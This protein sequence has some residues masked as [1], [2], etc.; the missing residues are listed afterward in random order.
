MKKII[1][2]FLLL[3]ITV[4]AY[5]QFTTT[6]IWEHPVMPTSSDTI[7][8]NPGSKLT[9]ADFRGQPNSNSVATAITASGFGYT[10]SMRSVNNRTSLVITVYCYF[11]KNNSWVKRGMKTDYAL[12]HE[13]HHFDITYIATAAFVNKLKDAVFTKSNYESL[14]EKL[15]SECYADL[16]KMQNAYDGDTKNGQ[17]KNVQAIWNDKLDLLLSQTVIH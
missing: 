9:W 5:P 1:F 12:T 7:N 13:Q 6:V 16:E 17:L 4:T 11:Q 15:N 14:L 10:M 2:P 8:Y 3:L